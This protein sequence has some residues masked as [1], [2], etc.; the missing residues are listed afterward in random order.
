MQLEGHQSGSSGITMF[1][2]FSFAYKSI[3][4]VWI[5]KENRV[6]SFGS[7]ILISSRFLSEVFYL[8]YWTGVIQRE[9]QMPCQQRM[10]NRAQ[11]IIC[12]RYNHINQPLIIQLVHHVIL[13]KIF[14]VSINSRKREDLWTMLGCVPIS[15]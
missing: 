8:I 4:R 6:V 11:L 9:W 1:Q 12:W 3:H 14:V 10:K 2:F 7:F 13:E 5:L 15:V